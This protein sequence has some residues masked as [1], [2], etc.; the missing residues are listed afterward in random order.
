MIM[1]TPIGLTLKKRIRKGPDNK[2]FI[3]FFFWLKGSSGLVRVN[4]RL[5]NIAYGPGLGGLKVGRNG[6]VYKGM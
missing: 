2:L 1:V 5:Q 3:V 4:S 6:W